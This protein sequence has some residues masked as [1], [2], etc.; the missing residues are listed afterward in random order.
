MEHLENKTHTEKTMKK[1]ETRRFCPKAVD[2]TLVNH[3]T[4]SSDKLAVVGRPLRNEQPVPCKIP[5]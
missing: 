5:Y 3:L 4:E 1:F 2:W